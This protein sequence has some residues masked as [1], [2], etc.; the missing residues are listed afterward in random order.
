MSNHP[1]GFNLNFQGTLCPRPIVQRDVLLERRLAEMADPAAEQ[2][3]GGVAWHNDKAK[4]GLNAHAVT[5][6]QRLPSGQYYLSN[7]PSVHH[8]VLRPT[9]NHYQ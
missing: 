5:H 2:S 6:A 1:K 7:G 3:R 4:A 9:A 8:A